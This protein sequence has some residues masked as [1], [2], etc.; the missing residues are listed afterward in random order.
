MPLGKSGKYF[1]NP[2]TMQSHGD[3]PDEQ[4]EPAVA[5]QDDPGG[6]EGH[7]TIHHIEIH[8]HGPSSEHP[9]HAEAHGHD[10]NIEHLG[11]HQN[12]DEAAQA[13]KMHMDGGTADDEAEMED[14]PHEEMAEHQKMSKAG[15]GAY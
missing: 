13:G 4:G 3:M 6:G 5:P 8:P 14:N 10:G 12:Y 1:S 11:D 7:P 2:K 9:H 15:N